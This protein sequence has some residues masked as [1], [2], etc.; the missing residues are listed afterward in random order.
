M[1]K[2]QF[3]SCLLA[4]FVLLAAG[5]ASAFPIALKSVS[6][7]IMSTPAIGSSNITALK[8]S[9]NLKTLMLIVSNQVVLN[10]GPTP[11]ANAAINLDPYSHDSVYGFRVYL[12]NST[13]YFYSLSSNNIAYFNISDITATINRPGTSEKDTMLA[14]LDIYGKGAN[15]TFYEYYVSGSGSLS[16]SINTKN[17]IMNLGM[18]LKSG[19]GHGVNQNSPE[20]ISA[21]GFVFQGSGIPAV[22]QPYSTFWYHSIAGYN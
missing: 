6:G 20:G 11:P 4:G 9:V 13:G 7:T 2:F 18:S 14:E 21:G 12:T 5:K 15:G 1:K 8:Y 22:L 19:A 16:S 10:G 17:N 3:L